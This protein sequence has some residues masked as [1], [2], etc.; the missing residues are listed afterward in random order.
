VGFRP[1]PW[2]WADRRYA[3]DNGRFKG[4]WDDQ[5]GK[6]RTIYTG[7]S[8]YGCL[9]KVLASLRPK[10]SVDDLVMAIEDE[11]NQ[12]ARYPDYPAGTINYSWLDE[13]AAGHARQNGRYYYVTHS[14]SV[15]ALRRQFDPAAFEISAADFDVSLLKDSAPRV[16]TRTIA[17][18]LFDNSTVDGV[19]FRS[20]HGDDLRMW[21]VFERHEDDTTSR[22]LT[23]RGLVS[24]SPESPDLVRAL[25]LHGI[26]WLD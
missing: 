12:D 2:A 3:T 6:F 5:F 13:R 17:R 15:A 18:W 26:H 16:L 19:E 23:E 22:H 10:R 24:L 11:D 21:A 4:R 25:Q 9:V 1:D 8:L 14:N 7:D 20:R